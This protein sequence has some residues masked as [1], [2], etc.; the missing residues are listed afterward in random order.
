MIKYNNNIKGI[1]IGENEFKITQFADDTTLFLDGSQ[2]SLQHTLNAIEI[3][4]SF[5]GLKIN[6]TK[7]KLWIGK[8]ET[9][10]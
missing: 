10:W 6:T 2:L 8:K 3:F 5:S 7:T 9:L 1:L 4:L